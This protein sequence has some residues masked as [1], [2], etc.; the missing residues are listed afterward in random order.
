MYFW[1]LKA[2]FPEAKHLKCGW[3]MGK[4]FDRCLPSSWNKERKQ[5]FKND[6]EECI[7][8]LSEEAAML[9]LQHLTSTHEAVPKLHKQLLS[10]RDFLPLV[11]MP[12]FHVGPVGC[13]GSSQPNESQVEGE[14]FAYAHLRSCC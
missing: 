13:Q 8:S 14:P 10:F 2:V 6:L 5:D 7:T 11:A 1:E 12:L 9:R 4:A 3:A